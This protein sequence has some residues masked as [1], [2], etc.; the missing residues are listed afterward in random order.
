M[1]LLT[2]DEARPWAQSI[3]EEVVSLRMP[4]RYAEPGFAPVRNGHNLSARDLDKIVD[5]AT[6]GTPEG[7]PATPSPSS[8]PNEDWRLGPPDLELTMSEPFTLPA[9][10]I[11]ATRSFVIPT[12]L[13]APRWLRAV[14]VRPGAPSIVRSVVAW[15]DTR[16]EARRRDA[17]DPAPGFDDEST[18]LGREWLVVWT[19]GEEPSSLDA[20]LGV[21][22][23]PRADLVVR[24]HY[25][26]TWRQ[27]GEAVSD[28]T[29][30]GLYFQATAPARPVRTLQIGSRAAPPPA[31]DRAA[32]KDGGA[33]DDKLGATLPEEIALVALVP[34]LE[35]PL[36]QLRVEAVRP[37]GHHVPLLLLSRP[38]PEWPARYWLER[39]L[40]L[41]RGARLVATPQ[42]GG[43]G[44]TVQLEY[45]TAAARRR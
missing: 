40:L 12:G 29:A 26:K 15:V 4:P 30:L 36:D 42:G 14:D 32:A 35:R 34:H 38:S 39:P 24:V 7:P 8:A 6:G 3:K 22:L 44:V 19:P 21:L 37:D 25:K 17:H 10:R 41:P 28:R 23:P 1:S 16:G 11:E 13:A 43:G 31:T 9:D 5:W 27:E 18:W 2:Y 20:G 45:T 33:A